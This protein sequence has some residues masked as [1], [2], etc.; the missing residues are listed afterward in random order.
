MTRS[1]L[2]KDQRRAREARKMVVAITSPDLR[3]LADEAA[4]ALERVERASAERLRAAIR[5][6]S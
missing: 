1:N 2:Q 6:D 5:P 3:E 4:A